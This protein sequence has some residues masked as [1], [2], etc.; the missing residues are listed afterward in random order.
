MIM[1]K[2]YSVSL[3]APA[4]TA[5]A[6]VSERFGDT[7][8][9]TSFLDSSHLDGDIAVGVERVCIQKGKTLTEKIT[10]IDTVNYVLEYDLIQGRPF[11]LKAASNRWEVVSTGVNSCSLIMSPIFTPKWWG[12][13]M[14]PVM[15]FSLKFILPKVLEEFKYWVET[16]D[17]HPRKKALL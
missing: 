2:Q 7:G 4:L 10:K 16:G 11:F 17:I 9:W 3:A 12:H 15:L 5:W 6:A 8:Q 14:M 1:Q 13:P